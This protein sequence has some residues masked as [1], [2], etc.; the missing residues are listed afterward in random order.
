LEEFRQAKREEITTLAQKVE[1]LARVYSPDRYNP[2]CPINE[3]APKVVDN[4]DN[5]PGAVPVEFYAIWMCQQGEVEL[6]PEE[7]Q[8]FAWFL[9]QQIRPPPIYSPTLK[10]P[11]VDW[12]KVNKWQIRN[13]PDPGHFAIQSAPQ[14]PTYYTSKHPGFLKYGSIRGCVGR[15]MSCGCVRCDPPFGMDR[16]LM[17][18]H[19][20]L[21][22]PTEPV[23]GH[24]WNGSE[25]VLYA[26]Y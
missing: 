20:V 14:D 25:W 22:M 11:R 19:G 1:V 17:T 8:K 13:L 23:H 9:A 10:K 18:N 2:S 12:T 24:V 26:G 21:S 16:G 7:E 5:L 4:V 3:S 6:T 15:A